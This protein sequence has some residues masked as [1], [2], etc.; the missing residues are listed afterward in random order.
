MLSESTDSFCLSKSLH[1]FRW[2]A[3]EFGMLLREHRDN[4]TNERMSM[5]LHP[6]LANSIA[7]GRLCFIIAHA[8]R[9]ILSRS[10]DL[11]VPIASHQ[12]DYPLTDVSRRANSTVQIDD[13][14]CRRIYKVMLTLRILPPL[15]LLLPFRMKN[16]QNMSE[17]LCVDKLGHF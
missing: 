1:W 2:N 7:S 14:R 16:G 17:E 6:T 10:L 15:P 8:H 3:V 13:V 5:V 9:E 12:A 4:S 11:H